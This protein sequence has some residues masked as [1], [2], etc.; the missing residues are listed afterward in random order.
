MHLKYTR[1]PKK[2]FTDT[3]CD[4]CL[5]CGAISC[6]HVVSQSKSITC[7]CTI[8]VK[9]KAHLVPIERCWKC[10]QLV[11]G[12][13]QTE[14][15][16]RIHRHKHKHK[17]TRMHTHN[18]SMFIFILHTTYSNF[19]WFS[20]WANNTR[21]SKSSNSGGGFRQ[22]SGLKFKQDR[23]LSFALHLPHSFSLCICSTLFVCEFHICAV[24]NFVC[25]DAYIFIFLCWISIDAK[26]FFI[27][28]AN[29]FRTHFYSFQARKKCK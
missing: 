4:T 5:T 29:N 20:S 24:L 26:I 28:F 10:T 14:M 22:L 7:M 25:D 9:I 16:G 21:T 2:Y 15:Q 27:S 13:T 19:D 18:P 1:N 11:F 6:H 23:P 8:K 17:H 12:F 3:N